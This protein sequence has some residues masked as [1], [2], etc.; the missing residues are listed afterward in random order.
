MFKDGRASGLG[1]YHFSEM[2]SSS[3]LT[4]YEGYLVNDLFEGFGSLFTK[5]QK[6]I[7][8]EFKEGMLSEKYV[9]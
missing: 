4:K 3:D 5:D 7:K 6:I 2:N 9:E 8:S 1:S